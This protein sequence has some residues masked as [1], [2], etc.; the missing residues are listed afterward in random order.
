MVYVTASTPRIQ[1]VHR[2]FGWSGRTEARRRPAGAAR[3]AAELGRRVGSRSVAVAD[4]PSGVVS[5]WVDHMNQVAPVVV[6][7]LGHSW[8]LLDERAHLLACA[9]SRLPSSSP[10]ILLRLSF[11]VNM[12]WMND[13]I[14]TYLF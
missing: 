7:R 12:I 10:S 9:G 11:G 8:Q 6:R 14:N 1:R 13:D 2:T 5:C 4:R 3:T